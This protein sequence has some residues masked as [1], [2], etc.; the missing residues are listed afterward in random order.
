MNWDGV[1]CKC[2][3]MEFVGKQ[4]FERIDYF[5]SKKASKK[6]Q[7][8]DAEKKKISEANGVKMIYFYY[9]ETISSKLIRERIDRCI[10]EE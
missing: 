7:I 1:F 4:H 10:A 2:S 3:L 9:Y 6:V 5:G 8:C